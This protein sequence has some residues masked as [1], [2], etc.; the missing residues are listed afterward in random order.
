MLSQFLTHRRLTS[1][2]LI[3]NIFFSKHHKKQRQE[4]KKGP[5]IY[6]DLIHLIKFNTIYIEMEDDID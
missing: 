6:G 3:R 1:N 2:F 5:K 4:F